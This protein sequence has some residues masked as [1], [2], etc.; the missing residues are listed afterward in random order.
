VAWKLVLRIE[1]RSLDQKLAARHDVQ[2][3]V[4][5]SDSASWTSHRGA[6]RRGCSFF[7]AV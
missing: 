5:E 1:L 4:L 6:T 2:R 7:P 3:L